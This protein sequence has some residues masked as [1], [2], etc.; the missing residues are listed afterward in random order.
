MTSGRAGRQ[1]AGHRERT[2]LDP[3][4]GTIKSIHCCDEL[5]FCLNV[6]SAKQE[7]FAVAENDL[8]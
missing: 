1:L 2:L 7:C 8:F 5:I 3:V 6:Q 4:T